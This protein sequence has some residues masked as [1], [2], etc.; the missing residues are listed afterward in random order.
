VIQFNEDRPAAWVCARARGLLRH[1]RTR[2]SFAHEAKSIMV[3]WQAIK[4]ALTDEDR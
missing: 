4:D 3:F 1:N 2:R